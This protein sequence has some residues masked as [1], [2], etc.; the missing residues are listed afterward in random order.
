VVIEMLDQLEGNITYLPEDEV[1]QQRFR[2]LMRPGHY[3]FG[4]TSR[5][6]RQFLRKYSHLLPATG[7]DM[8]KPV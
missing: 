5:I 1:L 2:Q 8:Q 3:S 7:M 6:G 4:A